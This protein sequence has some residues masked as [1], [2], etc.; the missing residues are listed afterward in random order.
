MTDNPNLMLELGTQDFSKN[1]SKNVE[2]SFPLTIHFLSLK[3][4]KKE[5]GKTI[6][7]CGCSPSNGNGMPI[8]KK[9]VLDILGCMSCLCSLLTLFYRT[10]LVYLYMWSPNSA[11]PI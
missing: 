8:R 7:L 5:E 9:C 3:G 4:K 6:L 1:Q 2:L 10:I 11:T